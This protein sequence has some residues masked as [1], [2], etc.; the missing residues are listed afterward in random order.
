[1]RPNP[2][3]RSARDAPLPPPPPATPSCAAQSLLGQVDLA[4][5]AAYALGM[6]VAGHL[7][8]R[9]DLR[10]FL[11]GGMVLSGV[12]T[13]LFGMVG[14]WEGF[15]GVVYVL[16]RTRLFGWTR[17]G[18]RIRQRGRHFAGSANQACLLYTSP[19]PRDNHRPEGWHLSEGKGA[20][21]CEARLLAGSGGWWREGWQRVHALC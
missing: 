6:F 1:M 5:L 16:G 3:P 4:F 20:V 15:R 18:A 13:T 2:L 11:S 8:D 9:M 12:M 10:V 19:S 17:P 14:G 21:A 7:G